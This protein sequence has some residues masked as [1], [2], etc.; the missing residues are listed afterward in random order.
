M[1][2]NHVTIGLVT[3]ATTA[4]AALSGCSAESVDTGAEAVGVAELGLDQNGECLV[5]D[6]VV[7]HTCQHANLGPFVSVAAQSYPGTVFNDINTPHTTFNIALPGSS[8]SFSGAVLFRPVVGGEYAFF[9]APGTPFS[10]FTST[11]DAVAIERGGAI[12]AELC[13]Q[14]DYVNIA[15]LE[16]PQT[17]TV[18]FGPS[19]Q[20]AIQTNVEFIGEEGCEACEHVHLDASRR[21]LPLPQFNNVGEAVIDHPIAFEV[22]SAV[23]LVQGSACFGTVTFSFSAAGG[24]LINCLYYA[25]PANPDFGLLGCSGGLQGGDE[26]EAD[27]FRLRINPGAA[28]QGTVSVELELEDGACHDHDHDE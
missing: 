19:A 20:Q 22:P 11:G 21:V 25:R 10:V 5:G 12:P 13:A 16:G 8:G 26:V 7:E 28:L 27:Y 3:A 18:V 17:Y 1:R 15:H 23:P 2:I 24:P 9:L 4:S 6:E 14:M